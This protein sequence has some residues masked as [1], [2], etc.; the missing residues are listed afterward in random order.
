MPS[1]IRTL[2]ALSSSDRILLLEALTVTAAVRAGLRVSQ[3]TAVRRYLDRWVDVKSRA[4]CESRTI[5]WA[6]SAIGAR[7]PG[8]TCL[9]EALAADCMLRRRG[10]AS[11]LKI[12]VRRG[13]ELGI[14]AHAWV[15][16][17]G[18]VVIGTAPALS[19]YVV[20]SSEQ[21]P[22]AAGY[23]RID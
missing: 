3:F 2:F 14:D 7:L 9:V 1:T 16:C 19:E 21:R 12:G 5:V 8:T 23:D 22:V 6:V 20:L 10:H 11:A 18:A 17:S 13:A 4:Q 15:E